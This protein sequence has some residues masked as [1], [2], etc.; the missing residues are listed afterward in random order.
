MGN[1]LMEAII[2]VILGTLLGS[3]WW[4]MRGRR[5]NVDSILTKYM[6]GLAGI[7]ALTATIMLRTIIY[8]SH[9]FKDIPRS[10]WDLYGIYRES[11][12]L[13]VGVISLVITL[14]PIRPRRATG[15]VANLTPRGW[16][17][18]IK[19][20]W[21]ILPGIIILL[22]LILTIAAGV[23]SEPDPETG[24]YFVYTVGLSESN[25]VSGSIYG[26]FFSIPALI[27]MGILILLAM[28]NLVLIARP[29]LNEN[30]RRDAETRLFRSRNIIAIATGSVS[31]HLALIL[32]SLERTASFRAFF[33]INN[34]VFKLQAPYEIFRPTLQWSSHIMWV[35]G[36]A[37]FM[38]VALALCVRKKHQRIHMGDYDH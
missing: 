17:S 12:P 3:L 38:T 32:S 19:A 5:G 31:I 18:F 8:F 15:R 34:E 26:W 9:I 11:I 24:R 27:C 25:K 30:S 33:T 36:I 20:R 2:P 35:V 16:F 1:S 22:I 13:M 7:L 6:I 14:I 10:A 28:I 21:F 4:I 23:A 37:L 29:A